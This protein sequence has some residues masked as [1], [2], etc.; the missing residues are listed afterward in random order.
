[1]MQHSSYVSTPEEATIRAR[2]AVKGE[3][4]NWLLLAMAKFKAGT[5]R[6]LESAKHGKTRF[7]ELVKASMKI[8][9]NNRYARGS[10]KIVQGI[11]KSIKAL[12]K[13]GGK[14]FNKRCRARE[15]VDDAIHRS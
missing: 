11:I 2:F 10:A 3:Y 7:A 14:N 8:I 13:L 1:M 4:A 12:Q 15:L 6:A 5:Q 9:G